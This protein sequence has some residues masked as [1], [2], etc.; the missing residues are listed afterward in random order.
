MLP[1][2]DSCFDGPDQSRPE[3]RLETPLIMAM[4]KNKSRARTLRHKVKIDFPNGQTYCRVGANV[5][6]MDEASVGLGNAR[7]TRRL[8]SRQ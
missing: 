8:E 3:G 5:F 6:L 2:H 4:L 1:E 7:S